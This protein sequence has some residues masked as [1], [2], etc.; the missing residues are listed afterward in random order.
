MTFQNS[1]PLHLR[2]HRSPEART[3]HYLATVL[4][5]AGIGAAFVSGVP[6]VGIVTT[7]L[8]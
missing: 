2:A 5:F 6:L 8:S 1:W 7:L 3:L 4:A